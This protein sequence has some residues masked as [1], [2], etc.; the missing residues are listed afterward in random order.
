[1]TLSQPQTLK[2]HK[3]EKT[4]YQTFNALNC[5]AFTHVQIFINYQWHAYFYPQNNT[6]TKIYDII[7]KQYNTFETP[8]SGKIKNQSTC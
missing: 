8:K 5:S 4:T 6:Y 3:L 2:G 1:M 7:T